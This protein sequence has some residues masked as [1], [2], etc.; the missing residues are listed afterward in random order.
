LKI[1]IS[2]IE[3]IKQTNYINR[4]ST[5]TYK[6]IGVLSI[7]GLLFNL[8]VS[9][10]SYLIFVLAII[11]SI[12]LV[13]ARVN[14]IRVD[15]KHFYHIRN[16]IIPNLTKV[17]GYEIEKL[18]SIRWKGYKSKFQRFFGRRTMPGIDYGIEISFKDD[19]SVSLDISMEQKDLDRILNVVKENIKKELNNVRHEEPL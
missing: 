18:K 8:N 16:S 10:E 9:L 5:W 14:D 7:I 4:T 17:N 3:T 12:V 15:D 6:S 13:V 11:L 1:Q 19:S 2:G